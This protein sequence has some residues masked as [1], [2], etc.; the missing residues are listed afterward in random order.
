MRLRYVTFTGVDHQTD[1][2]ELVKIQREYPFVEFGILLSTDWSSNNERFP[3]PAILK[4][5]SGWGLNL[6]AHLCGDLA[7]FALNGEFIPAIDLCKG[8]FHLFRRCQ[9]NCHISE[10]KKSLIR[11][12]CGVQDCEHFIL[13][14]HTPDLCRNFLKG[15]YNGHIDCLLDAS[16]GRG[17]NTPIEVVTSPGT[18]IGYAGGITPDNVEG[19]LRLLL[20]HDSNDEFWIDMETGVRTNELF[21]LEKVRSVLETV[22]RLLKEYDFYPDSPTLKTSEALDFSELKKKYEKGKP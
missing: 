14:M 11:K 4:S 12:F 21:D 10:G 9:L 8:Y 5:L 17:I 2:Q 19:K 1:V 18:L 16:R 15:K 7:R 6:S 22:T 13:Q 3:D 20:K